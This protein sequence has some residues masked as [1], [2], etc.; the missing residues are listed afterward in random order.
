[1]GDFVVE[2]SIGERSDEIDQIT[3]SYNEVIDVELAE[4]NAGFTENNEILL[5]L[6]NS[7][8]M[9]LDQLKPL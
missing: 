8:N 7:P 6:S 2:E 3:S 4:F 9:E 5:A 1:M